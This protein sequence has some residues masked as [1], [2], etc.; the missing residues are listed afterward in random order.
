MADELPNG[1]AVLY[2]L[3]GSTIA[4]QR[5]FNRGQSVNEIDTSSKDSPAKTVVGGRY[6]SSGSFECVYTE[7]DFATVETAIQARDLVTL[8]KV[9][10][11]V[12]EVEAE[13]LLTSLSEEHPDQ[14]TSTFSVEFTVSGTWDAAGS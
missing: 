7:A 2:F 14:D 12:P 8:A 9:V 1:T 10:D 13:V 3:D 6:E 11:G 4:G 5:S